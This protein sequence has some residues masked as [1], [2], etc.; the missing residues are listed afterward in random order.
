MGLSDILGARAYGVSLLGFCRHW[1]IYALHE[2]AAL[3]LKSGWGNQAGR[4]LLNTLGA[5]V[6]GVSQLAFKAAA[7]M[8]KYCLVFKLT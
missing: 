6:C 1:P 3:G 8:A 4:G 5:P 2:S 7:L